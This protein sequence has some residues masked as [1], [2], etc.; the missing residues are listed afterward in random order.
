[1]SLKLNERYPGRFNNP[2]AGYPQGSF[3]NRTTPTAKDGSYLEQDWANDKE[4]FFQSLLSDAGVT[5]NGAVDSVGSSQ[6][7]DSLRQIIRGLIQDAA[8]IVG[9]IRNGKMTVPAASATAT[10]TASEVVVK[11][12]I[13]GF[14]YLLPSFSKTI[15]LATTG[16]GGMDAGAAPTSGYVS[17]YAIYNPVSETSALLACSQATS[18]GPVYS[19]A[20][21]PAGY[22]ASALVSSWG[23]TAGG[24][25]RAGAQVDRTVSFSIISVLNTSTPAGTFTLFTLAAAVPLNAMSYFGSFTAVS[26]LTG[27]IGLIIAASSGGFGAQNINNSGTQITSSFNIPIIG[28]QQSYYLTASTSGAPNFTVG[29]TGYT[30]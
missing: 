20:N 13:G 15:N 24:L 12:A 1:M 7:Y 3:K 18:N 21:M 10:F 6:L 23:T 2:S 8:P 29:A 17:I 19:G 30:F 16:A 9:T 5:A 26:T 28:A 22:T 14:V 27:T 25:L 11:T 4:G